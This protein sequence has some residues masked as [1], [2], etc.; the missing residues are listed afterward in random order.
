MVSEPWERLWDNAMVAI[1]SIA[2][3]FPAGFGWSFG[4]GTA[5]RLFYDHRE[6]RDI[7]IFVTDPYVLSALSPRLND[8]TE[9]LTRGAY[10]EMSNYLKL[11]FDDG[12]VDIIIGVRLLRDVNFVMKEVR[13]RSVDVETPIEIVAKKCFYR[14][15]QF[16]ARDIFD[17]AVIITQEPRVVE[18]YRAMLLTKRNQLERRLGAL[19]TPIEAT[20]GPNPDAALRR[21]AVQETIDAIDA[22]SAFSWIKPIA[23][24][25]VL[26]FIG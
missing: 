20:S 2:H 22:R 21:I 16:S 12:E 9:R 3:R 17:L 7:D 11:R 23:I 18:R 25:T 5:M 14:A 4:G 6:S 24:D 13:G 10:D 8:T 15:D 19:R 1:D 26:D